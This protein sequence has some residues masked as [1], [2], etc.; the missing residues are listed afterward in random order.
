VALP[1]L[2]VGVMPAGFEFP[3][4]QTELWVPF[5]PPA[6]PPRARMA[7]PAIARIRDDVTLE[8]AAGEVNAILPQPA[9]H[10]GRDR[11]PRFELVRMVEPTSL[12]TTP[13]PNRQP[14]IGAANTG[15]SPVDTGQP[16]LSERC[17]DPSGCRP[18]IH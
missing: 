4:A 3:D 8:A 14:P 10:Q 7:R 16:G 9:D 17:G 13:D 6:L 18:R 15:S 1:H 2:V 12:A 11:R 5:V